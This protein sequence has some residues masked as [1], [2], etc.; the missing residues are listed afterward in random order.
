MEYRE[1]GSTGLRISEIGFGCAHTG[2]L[3]PF[4]NPEERREAVA[5]AI[6]LGINYFDTAPAYA[7]G[8]SELHL[9]QAFKELG[10]RPL[11]NTKIMIDP[12][13]VDDIASGLVRC[14]DDS[15]ERLQLDRVDVIHLHQ[16]I[17]ERRLIGGGA[18][19]G[20]LLSVA[21]VLGPKGML[22]GFHRVRSAGKAQF[23][24]LN[25]L[26]GEAPAVRQV[27]DSGEL[28]SIMVSYNL[29]NPTAGMP[30]PTGFDRPDYGQSM[31]RAAA[32]GMGVV[33]AA[34]LATGALSGAPP[35]PLA[36]GREGARYEENASLADAFR[37]LVEEE[38]GTMAQA[39]LRFVLSRP[40]VCTVLVGFSCKEHIDEAV[41]CS[42]GKGLSPA[43][44][45]HL[46]EFY[47][48]GFRGFASG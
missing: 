8:L 36:T 27:I 3:L 45:A 4:G 31:V 33:V 24:G 34:P 39:A 43:A 26:G 17:A 18:T 28:H 14:V 41:A 42:D 11:I 1:L 9:G 48:R 16:R 25:G 35:H 13:E 40:E 38:G 30:P 22:E 20:M 19:H 15:L 6:E 44:R 47:S 12:E 46:S 37:F 7:D 23:F 5:R 32:R 29:L 10:V 2:G 21:D